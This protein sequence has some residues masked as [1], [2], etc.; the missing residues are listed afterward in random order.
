MVLTKRKPILSVAER[1]KEALKTFTTAL[2]EFTDINNDI[3]LERDQI[4]EEMEELQARSTELMFLE[5][6]NANF[7]TKLEEFLS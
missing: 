1:S 6:K 2:Q 4:R 7:I 5:I 3:N